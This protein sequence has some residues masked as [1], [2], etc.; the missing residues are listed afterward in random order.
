ML[1]QISY[2]QNDELRVLWWTLYCKNM[3]YIEDL[4][5]GR[6]GVMVDNGQWTL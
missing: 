1:E 6:L 2:F 3:N 4:E 5:K